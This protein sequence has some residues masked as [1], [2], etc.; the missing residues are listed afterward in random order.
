MVK[1]IMHGCNGAMGQVITKLASEDND[2]EIVAG[3][4][5]ADN[6]ETRIWCSHPAMHVMW[7][8]MDC[9]FFS[10]TGCG[11]RSGVCAET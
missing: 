9:R 11:W 5:C 2:A 6:R 3:I 10:G 1:M 4:D 8:Q 7:M